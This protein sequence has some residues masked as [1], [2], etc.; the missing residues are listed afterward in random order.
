MSTDNIMILAY[1]LTWIALVGILT[2]A[3]GQMAL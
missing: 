3:A 2:Y 1:G